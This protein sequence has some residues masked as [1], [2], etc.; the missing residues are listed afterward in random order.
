LLG[1]AGIAIWSSGE[2]PKF[3]AL[4]ARGGFRVEKVKAR[5]NGAR[6]GA[7]HIIWLASLPR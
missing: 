5:A 3:E 1:R 7:R 6:G 4:L 2:N